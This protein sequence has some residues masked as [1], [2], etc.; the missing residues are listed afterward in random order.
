MIDS[1]TMTPELAR[2]VVGQ[3]TRHLLNI[4]SPNGRFI[5][6]HKAGSVV[7]AGDGYNM[8]RHCGTLWFMLRAVNETGVRLDWL[9]RAKLTAGVSYAGTRI[10][11]VTW[12]GGPKPRYG[13]VTKGA[14]KTG[15]IGLALVMLHE[16]DRF[17]EQADIKAVRLPEPVGRT[18]EGL[19][20][21]AT[22]QI[23]RGDFF[24]KRRLKDGA[25]SDFVSDY[26]TGEVLL[27]L[28]HSP[29]P[30][31]QAAEVCRGLMED[32]YGIGVQ[33]HWMAYAACEAVERGIVDRDVGL[34]YLTRLM[35]AIID[36][37]AYRARRESTPIACRSEALTRALMLARRIE[38]AFP[39][40]L[41]A[42]MRHAAEENMALQLEWYDRGQFWKGD[43]S[44]KVQID[45]IQHN[46]TAFL[47]WLALN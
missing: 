31:R 16:F 8:L 15:G 45:Y 46:A 7:D 2:E 1:K 23:H 19:E 38:D 42:E 37:T 44:R 14:I 32:D 12:A 18:V 11:R 3:G 39:E 24:H 27:G 41:V 20:D 29:R 5:Y 9:D 21:Y 6:S 35:R 43:T 36:D 22:G 13:M 33:S 47:N 28:F 30:Q 10:E 26:Y 34:A 17:A 25:I 40:S 4:L